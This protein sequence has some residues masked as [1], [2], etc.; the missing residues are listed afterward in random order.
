MIKLEKKE[1][2]PK[3]VSA[4]KAAKV[5]KLEKI[6]TPKKRAVRKTDAIH[7]VAYV[8]FTGNQI[9]VSDVMEKV[10]AHYKENFEKE[11]GALKSVSLYIK[12]E[13]SVAYYVVNGVGSDDYKV[14][15]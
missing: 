3:V 14:E 7:T 5:V 12:P 15:I 4:A 10:R 2:T 1:V 11:S 9:N 8:E 6:E 13:C